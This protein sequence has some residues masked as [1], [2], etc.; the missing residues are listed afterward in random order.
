[1]LF[2]NIQCDFVTFLNGP[3]SPFFD[4]LRRKHLM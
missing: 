4:M 3:N 1:L 2:T